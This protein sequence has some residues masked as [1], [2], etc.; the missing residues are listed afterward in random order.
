MRR[1]LT[2]MAIAAAAVLP[3]AAHATAFTGSFTITETYSDATNGGGGGPVITGNS[4]WE[5]G[6][7][8]NAY[9]TAG[10]FSIIAGGAAQNLATFA[11]DGTCQGPGCIY[12]GGRHF[13]TDQFTVVFTLKDPNNT[14]QTPRAVRFWLNTTAPSR[15]SALIQSVSHNP[16]A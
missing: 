9:G 4:G 7:N 3:I 5:T 10:N 13:E 16:T 8:N 15:A 2:A 11:P 6:I 1:I 12:S 14:V